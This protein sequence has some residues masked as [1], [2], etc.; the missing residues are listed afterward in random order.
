MKNT[1]GSLSRFQGKAKRSHSMLALA[2]NDVVNKLHI[3]KP[4]G[5]KRDLGATEYYPCLR[6]QC[7]KIPGKRQHLGNV[8][9]IAGKAIHIGTLGIQPLKNIIPSVAQIGFDDN[10]RKTALF[11]RRTQ[12]SDGK[13]RMRI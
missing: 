2:A 13:I 4:L 5:I 9:D 10:R 6:Q 3:I 1:L 12:T 8:P 11:Q 7:R